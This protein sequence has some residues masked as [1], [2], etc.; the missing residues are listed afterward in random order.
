MR[1]IDV[2]HHMNFSKPSVSHAV[3][4]LQKR[5]YLKMSS[6]GFLILTDKGNELAMKVYERHCFFK[7][8]LMQVGV[9]PEIAEKDACQIE[10]IISEETFQQLK[11][12]LL[13]V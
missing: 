9:E 3:K 5:G 13:L 10:H 2:A 1:S 12:K 11:N 4:E 8:F 7:N 6:E